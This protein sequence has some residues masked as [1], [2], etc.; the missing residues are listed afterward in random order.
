MGTIDDYLAG[1][2]P[3]DAALI[4]RCYTVATQAVAG[5]DQ[6]VGYGMAA[7]RLNGSPLLAVMAAR[8]HIG[9]YPFSPAA[10]AAVAESAPSVPGVTLAKGTIRFQRDHPLPDGIVR[11]L[12][13]ARAA[14]I[15]GNS[16]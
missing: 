7:L 11:R 6:G 10:V 8:K 15:T 9:V 5:T 16:D 12:V 13:Q 14:E 1:I 2:E 4:S 3:D